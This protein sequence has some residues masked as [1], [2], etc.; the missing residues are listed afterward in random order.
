M[1]RLKK[2]FCLCCISKDKNLNEK[3]YDDNYVS[4]N[5][6]Q[7]NKYYKVKYIL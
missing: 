3:N 5:S 2:Y 4:Y 6:N 7:Y 1:F